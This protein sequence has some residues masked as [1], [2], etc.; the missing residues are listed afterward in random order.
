MGRIAQIIV[1]LQYRLA[2]SSLTRIEIQLDRQDR[3]S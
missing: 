2:W 3:R 1:T